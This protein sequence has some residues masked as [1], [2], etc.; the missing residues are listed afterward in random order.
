MHDGVLFMTSA[1]SRPVTPM[2]CLMCALIGGLSFSQVYALQSVLP[3]IVADLGV[4]VA[5]AGSTIGATLLAM[6]VVSPFMGMVSDALGRR[7]LMVAAAA[8]LAVPTAAICFAQSL[9]QI[10]FLRFMQGLVVPGMTV[11]LLAYLAEEFSTAG[12]IRLTA[13]YISGSVLGGFLG[14]FSLGYLNQS[15]GWRQ[16]MLYMALVSVLGAVLIW[17]GLP[18]SRHFQANR[19]LGQSWQMVRRHLRERQLF[20]SCVLGFCLSFCLMACFTYIN[21]HLAAAPYRFNTAQLA[22]VFAVYLL[23]MVVTPLAGRAMAD[24]GLR[25]TALVATA[26]T[27][28]GLL[29]SLH[30]HVWLI[31][32]A[33]ALISCGIFVAQIAAINHLAQHIH[34]G[35]SLASGLYY[36][37]YYTG[38]FC[39]TWLCG[40]AFAWQGWAATVAV[41]LVV[42]VV[43][44]AMC[45]RHMQ[46]QEVCE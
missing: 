46:R 17:R 34:E 9:G 43:A 8:V 14:R 22:D 11:V 39:G 12:R 31:I 37:G 13:F 44:V 5:A 18:P 25:P 1:A 32:V 35:R 21:L 41:M 4:S 38:G 26:C 28:V 36:T 42:Q 29:L 45:W 16:G 30:G 6:A 15:M 24:F 10:W 33:L 3:A 7:G 40:Y 27:A 19:H 23:G 2:F 20:V